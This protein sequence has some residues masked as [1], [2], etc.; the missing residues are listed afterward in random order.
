[1]LRK[2]T[3]CE[4]GANLFLNGRK[5]HFDFYQSG[6]NTHSFLITKTHFSIF[7][8]DLK[9]FDLNIVFK[10]KDKFSILSM[11]QYL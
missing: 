2:I 8:N 7:E 5:H 1:M 6:F 9:Q 11:F 10:N 3:K 4:N